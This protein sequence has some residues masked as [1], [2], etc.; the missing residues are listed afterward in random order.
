MYFFKYT[1]ARPGAWRLGRKEKKKIRAHF[2]ALRSGR[3]PVREFLQS[4]SKEDRKKVGEDIK[5]CEIGW[6]LGMPL[7][8]ALRDSIFEVRTGLKEKLVRVLFSVE[9][10]FMV[11]YHAFFKDRKKTDETDISLGVKRRRDYIGKK[12]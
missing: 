2:Y 5:A 7:C 12:E 4:L 10:S 11:L 3:E 1:K 9:G 8:R 6:P